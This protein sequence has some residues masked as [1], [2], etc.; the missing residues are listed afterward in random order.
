[1]LG[2]TLTQLQSSIQARGH[3]ADTVS[4]QTD[5]INATLRR[6][7]GMRRWQFL[8]ARAP[9]NLLATVNNPVVSLTGVAD[10]LHVDAVRVEKGLDTW[11]LDYLPAEELRRREWADR[12]ADRPLYWTRQGDELWLYPRPNQAYIVGVDYIKTPVDLVAGADRAALP[13]TYTDVVVW[14]ALIDLAFRQRDWNAAA[15]AE[16]QFEKRLAEMIVQFGLKQRQTSS[17]VAAWDGW[18]GW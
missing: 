13:A 8:D 9:T 7:Y 17:Q 15:I 4:A 12:Q 18:E 3:G 11:D 14:G 6:L 2:P 5:A 16:R 1:M 10:L